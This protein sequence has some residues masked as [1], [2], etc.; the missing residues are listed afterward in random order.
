METWTVISND[1]SLNVATCGDGPA[2][3]L[4]HGWPHTWQLW[5]EVMPVLAEAGLR[6]IA[7]DLRG[8]GASAR[9]SDG[10]DVDT[11][12][13]DMIGLLDA[14]R[15]DRATVVGIDAG[16]PIAFMLALREP[17]R[18]SHLALSECLIGQLPGAEAF[19]SKGPPWW[20][21]FH[22]VPGLAET[23]VEGHEDEYLDW[24]LTTGTFDRKGIPADVR[25]AFVDAYR[26]L[27]ALR[28]GFEYYRASARNA[29]QIQAALV[30]VQIRQPCLAILGGV[31]GDAIQR[32]LVPVAPNLR[33]VEVPESG[34]LVPLEQPQLFAD[35]II[36]LAR[37]N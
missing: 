24:F 22:A 17:A 33:Y 13:T 16:G 9:V 26:G 2:V 19:L 32:Q 35:A 11:L 36:A 14:L 34:H 15:I 28:C 12:A 29:E 6:A 18:V 30:G 37:Q 31:V 3:L 20:F 7:P 23:V 25:D 10:Y 21:G 4:L 1:V 27:E 5:R 8:L